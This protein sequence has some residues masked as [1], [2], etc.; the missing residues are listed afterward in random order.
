MTAVEQAPSPTPAPKS[1]LWHRLY[2]GETNFDFV[3]KRRIGFTISAV[4]I[5]ASTISLIFNGL[6]LGIDFKGGVAWEFQANGQTVDDARNV[7]ESN[8]INAAD[9]K[10]QTLSGASGE[11]IRVQ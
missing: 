5:V 8:G 4:L 3:G 7:L 2:H 1:S 10:I 6:N 9:A 11:R